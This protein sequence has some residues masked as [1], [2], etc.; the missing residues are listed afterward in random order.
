MNELTLILVD[1]KATLCNAWE[2]YFEG[3]PNIEIVNGYFEQL[4][5]YD[6]MVSAANSFGLMDGGVDLAIVRYFGGDLMYR[7]QNQIKE[8]YLG[9]Q[10]VG[11][12]MIV[13]TGHEHHP[14]LAHTPTMRIP[15]P[16][17]H[18]DNVYLAMWAM[19]NAVHKFNK[20][21]QGVI[22]KIACPGLGTATGKVPMPEAAH[23]MSLAYKHYLH[24]PQ[25]LDWTLATERQEKIIYGGDLGFHFPPKE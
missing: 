16:I 9:E 21:G 5:D 7:V 3:L 12:A 22:K 19:L 20:S 4:T 8:E 14:Y 25:R 2:T 11:T 24:P 23:Q 10:P 15:M 6:C 1:P 18:T 17:A 13:E